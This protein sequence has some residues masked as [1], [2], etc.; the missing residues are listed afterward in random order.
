[1]FEQ[2]K[3]SQILDILGNKNRRRIIDLLNSKPCFVTEISDKLSINPKAV[4]EHLALLQKE[5]VI[6][7][8]C[9]DK[10]RK[11]YYLLREINLSIKMDPK[12]NDLQESHAGL[13][14]LADILSHLKELMTRRR[15]L[16]QKLESIEKD[17]DQKMEELVVNSSTVCTDESEPEILLALLHTPMTP[18]E[19][20]D[21]CG[22]PIPEI[23]AALH[24]LV[25]NGYL[26]NSTGKYAIRDDILPTK[27]I[28]N[29]SY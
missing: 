19:L 6:G 18:I 22:R 14:P 11:Y 15:E 26:E 1:M 9:D 20:A 3:I 28:T 13:L 16:M 21:A 10:R 8:Y 25:A 12:E 24:S 4:I 27:A 5:D 2:D 29:G 23:T 7:S 17:L